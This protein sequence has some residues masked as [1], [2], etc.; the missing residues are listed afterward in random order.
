MVKPIL[1]LDMGVYMNTGGPAP[2][3]PAWTYIGC[4]DTASVSLTTAELD[5][6]CAS[7]QGWKETLAGQHSWSIPISGIVRHADGADATLN[8]T[9]E[10]LMDMEMSRTLLQVQFQVGKGIGTAIYTGEAH[11]TKTDISANI[12]DPGKF[13]STLSGTGPL[14]KS[15]ATI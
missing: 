3:P 15:V 6:T 13:S 1:G 12:K 9:A 4:Y 14:V 5:V 10:N 2:A 7:S 8:V 11:L